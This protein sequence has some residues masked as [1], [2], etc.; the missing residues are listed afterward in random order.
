VAGH[1]LQPSALLALLAPLRSQALNSAQLAPL[2]LLDAAA[3]PWGP[4]W[5]DVAR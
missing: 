2:V 4:D 1:G 5:E 3:E